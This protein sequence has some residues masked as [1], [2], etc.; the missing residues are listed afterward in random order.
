MFFSLFDYYFELKGVY[1][2]QWSYLTNDEV[3]RLLQAL[4]WQIQALP[5]L[6]PEMRKMQAYVYSSQASTMTW[7][8]IFPF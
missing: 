8:T 3:T 5:L 2:G 1:T 6:L 4:R 7:R